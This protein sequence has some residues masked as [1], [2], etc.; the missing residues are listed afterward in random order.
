MCLKGTGSKDNGA[1]GINK[2]TIPHGFAAR[3]MNFKAFL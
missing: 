2:I 1:R 3:A